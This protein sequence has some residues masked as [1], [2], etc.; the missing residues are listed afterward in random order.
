MGIGRRAESAGAVELELGGSWL[1]VDGPTQM[2]ALHC[3][4]HTRS[5]LRTGQQPRRGHHIP[6][7]LPCKLGPARAH[8]HAH[9]VAVRR[10]GV[11]APARVRAA[12]R[13]PGP[14]LRLHARHDAQGAPP[15][16]PPIHLLHC[17]CH[18]L[19]RGVG[20]VGKEVGRAAAD[21]WVAC[22]PRRSAQ[23]YRAWPHGAEQL[24]K[25]L[26]GGVG[27]QLSNC[28]INSGQ[29]RGIGSGLNCGCAR[30]AVWC[31]RG[32]AG[33]R[34]IQGATGRRLI[35]QA[36]RP[37]PRGTGEG[38]PERECAVKAGCRRIVHDCSR[39]RRLQA[40]GLPTVDF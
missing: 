33:R 16:A 18:E 17:G 8:P 15:Q 26:L 38:P 11:V 39:L 23:R 2:D 25:L 34:L 32:A 7:A 20:D 1:S 4:C 12:R 9:G 31:H 40:C 24:L 37:H 19:G 27:V 5:C 22:P 35:L 14:G 29:R 21:G 6:L 30:A 3:L 28:G 10:R 36:R 13:G